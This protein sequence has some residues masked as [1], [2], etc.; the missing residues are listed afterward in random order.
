MPTFNFTSPEGKSYKVT[1]PE[2]ATS[3]QAFS[4]LQS[5]IGAQQAPQ[6][7]AAPQQ[8]APLFTAENPL[9]MV[10]RAATKA[11]K[12]TAALPMQ[13]ARTAEDIVLNTGR[14]VD[15][16]GVGA[17]QLANDTGLLNKLGIDQEG[18][19]NFLQQEAQ[20]LKPTEDTTTL[21][22]VSAALPSV[23]L[24]MVP[25][26]GIAKGLGV[27]NQVA[28]RVIGSGFI[29][30]LVGAL[31]G[32]TAEDSLAQNVAIGGISGIVGQGVGELPKAVA[33]RL[34]GG[35]AVA[36]GVGALDG[37][38]TE[39][40]LAQ[41]A[42]IGGIGAVVL[43]K[44]I[45]AGYG[46]I[47]KLFNPT[48]AAEQV[49]VEKLIQSL[50]PE[51]L[52]LLKES[53][54][55]ARTIGEV[56]GNP[57]A[58]AEQT[59]LARGFQGKQFGDEIARQQDLAG[60]A[61]QEANAVAPVGAAGDNA[62]YT[63]D[64][65][66]A[67]V[68]EQ[69][70]RSAAEQAKVSGLKS[71]IQQQIQKQE[72]QIKQAELAKQTADTQEINAIN[73][74]ILEQNKNLEILKKQ[75]EDLIASENVRLGQKAKETQNTL[76]A[77]TSELPTSPE[78]PFKTGQILRERTKAAET[79]A[80]EKMT[81]RVKELGLDKKTPIA[82]TE[83][84]T[85]PIKKWLDN[86]DNVA[87][88]N[89]TGDT[90]IGFVK[91]IADLALPE[92]K[93]ITFGDVQTLTQELGSR[94]GKAK[95]EGNPQDVMKLQ[96][97][98]DLVDDF[99][100]KKTAIGKNYKTF[101]DE[102]KKT[103]VEPFYNSSIKSITGVGA[104]NA[105]KTNY[106]NIGAK[107][108]SANKDTNAKAFTKILSEDPQALDAI[109]EYAIN[110]L[111]K[112]A[113]SNGKI[114]PVAVQRWVKKNSSVLE[115]FPDIKN[116]VLGKQAKLNE[117]VKSLEDIQSEQALLK[118]ENTINQ[119]IADVNK[120]I[121]DIEN[122]KALSQASIEKAKK[123]QEKVLTSLENRRAALSRRF[124]NI[125]KIQEV[126]ARNRITKENNALDS[127][128][129]TSPEKAIEGAIKNPQQIDAL[130]KT[131]EGNNDALNA[132]KRAAWDNLT[133]KNSKQ[134]ISYLE[135]NKRNLNKV[136][137]P[138]HIAALKKL[139]D[140]KGVM[141]TVSL[142]QPQPFTNA[143]QSREA[144]DIGLTQTI[145]GFMKRSA[146]RKMVK[147]IGNREE[148]IWEKALWD[149]E[150]TKKLLA[151]S[152]A[153]MTEAEAKYKARELSKLATSLVIRESDEE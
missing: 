53:P 113:S 55:D 108:F 151:A 100:I 111:A 134:I 21:G 27:A 73:N 89:I 31:E 101:R 60:K 105:P 48:N 153:K 91:K 64:A 1:A 69:E 86:L 54:V 70:G 147:F 67:R 94:I 25:A 65:L 2:G 82:T 96:E 71:Q 50:S 44:A 32:R 107:L 78:I 141:E 129:K 6:Q 98:Q 148:E 24:S 125:D 61:L 58:L 41:N 109:K 19:K 47:K 126:M 103:V 131:L 123:A 51:Q 104:A 9:G 88:L 43:P 26:T 10:G 110:D 39:D 144:G 142:K 132:F 106:E 93:S 7:Q 76:D 122:N 152:E 57:Q 74:S 143:V 140:E 59:N 119:N 35:G 5:Q 118:T 40:S 20:N 84:F 56:T 135:Q 33:R 15:Q 30:S 16:L 79:V 97:V 146:I 8:R 23:A 85:K 120:R 62:Q 127:F 83:A 145:S 133:N 80:K 114:N 117:I 34:I 102:Y 128:F 22:R 17:A 12:D 138:D 81:Q 92:G 87:R 52:N 13:A 137:S 18:F 124:E 49:V 116:S 63:A 14:G 37:R 149:K 136:F 130:L 28:Q 36:A 139:A 3:E 150:F 121:K 115:E 99:V 11:L 75:R 45:G 90:N 112:S 72:I 77:F 42:A 38:T 66:K 95:L 29:N 68:M 4:V 46:A